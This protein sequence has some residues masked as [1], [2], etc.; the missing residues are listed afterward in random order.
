[1]KAKMIAAV[2]ERQEAIVR[3]TGR[4]EIL[5]YFSVLYTANIRQKPMH[6]FTQLIWNSNPPLS[7]L[8]SYF[9]LKPVK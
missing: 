9:E 5:D 1:M 8:E 3:E 7:M 6:A 2:H 4:T